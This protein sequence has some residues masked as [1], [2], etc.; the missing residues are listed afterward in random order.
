[1][2]GN[3]KAMLLGIEMVGDDPTFRN[4]VVAP[5]I[6]VRRMTVAGH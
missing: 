5:T 6:K 1:M 2:A 4:G 3:L